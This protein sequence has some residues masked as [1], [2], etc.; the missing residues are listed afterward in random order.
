MIGNGQLKVF[1][2]INLGG[3]EKWE[4][5]YAKY[6]KEQSDILKMKKRQCF[7]GNM[8]Q[9]VNVLIEIMRKLNYK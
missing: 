4:Q 3:N 6:V 5:S 9:I 1:R 8:V 2:T 7:T